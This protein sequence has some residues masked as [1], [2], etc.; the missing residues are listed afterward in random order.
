[1]QAISRMPLAWSLSV[2]PTQIY[3]ELKLHPPL[4]VCGI[5]PGFSFLTH[6]KIVFSGNQSLKVYLLELWFPSINQKVKILRTHTHT[7]TTPHTLE[8]KSNLTV[9]WLD[10]EILL[11]FHSLNTHHTRSLMLWSQGSKFTVVQPGWNVPKAQWQA[12]EAIY[13]QISF[14]VPTMGMVS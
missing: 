4:I 1:M 2:K 3:K 9:L 11:L 8:L 5:N 6:W 7:H 12:P 13:D 10:S 14:V